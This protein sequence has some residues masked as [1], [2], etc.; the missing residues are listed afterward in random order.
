MGTS[1]AGT[2]IPAV[3]DFDD[4]GRDDVVT[5]D[6]FWRHTLDGATGRDLVPVT[7]WAGYHLPTIVQGF[8]F[9]DGA[10]VL[11]LG[12]NYS[13]VAETLAGEQIWWKPFMSRWHPGAVADV[14]GDGHLEIGAPTWG[15]VYHWPAPFAPLPGLGRAFACLAA[16][17]GEVKWTYDPGVAMSGVVTADVDGDGLSEFLFGTADGRLIALRGGADDKR[18]VVF[19]VQ[20]PAALGTP[21]VCDPIGWGRMHILVGCADGNLYA[22]T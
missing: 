14:D 9:K 7:Q 13:L 1:R 16:A 8:E 15:Q 2:Y 17:T 3:W 11:W 5:R 22:L 6:L 21:I 12:G 18:R 19:S 10:A 20:L 4:D